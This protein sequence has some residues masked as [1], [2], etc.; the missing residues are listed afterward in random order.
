MLLGL[1]RRKEGNFDIF[2]RLENE[3]WEKI[4]AWAKVT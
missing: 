2:E 4:V 1:R 3:K